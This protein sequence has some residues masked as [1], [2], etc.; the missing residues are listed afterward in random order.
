ML[1]LLV[2]A[3]IGC[4][5]P[6]VGLANPVDR[7][8]DASVSIE[9]VLPFGSIP[10]GSGTLVR[11]DELGL[12]ILTA[13][14]VALALYGW[15][16]QACSLEEHECVV[17]NEFYFESGMDLPDDWAFYP[18]EDKPK[19]MHPAKIGDSTDIE[20]G[21][22]LWLAGNPDGY[23]SSVVEGNLAWTYG[24]I[25]RVHGYA[26]PGSSGGGCF[27]EKGRLVGIIVAGPI[28]SDIFGFPAFETDLPYI[29]PIGNVR[30]LN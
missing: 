9:V 12:G 19:G 30:I 26:Y 10:I 17:L 18:I 2:A 14:H 8:V 25:W 15:P 3:L 20:V 4:A 28:V 29:V 13:E 21:D 11:D 5:V 6:D 22:R 1:K 27:D 23:L 7:I 16:Y 24:D